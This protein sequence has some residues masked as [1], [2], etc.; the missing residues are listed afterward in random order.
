MIY[1]VITALLALYCEGRHSKG[2]RNDNNSRDLLPCPDW[3]SPHT[4][5]CPHPDGVVIAG[6]SFSGHGKKVALVD[7]HRQRIVSLTA[8]DDNRKNVGMVY[9]PHT[10]MLTVAG[11][12]IYNV[13]DR[14]LT[15]T[16]VVMQLNM[17]KENAEW[18]TFKQLPH[19]ASNPMMVCDDEYL[20][21][22]G[23]IGCA[24]CFRISR[25]KPVEW[26]ALDDLQQVAPGNEYDGSLYSGAVVYHGT[27]TVLTRTKYMMLNGLKWD[28]KEYRD[29]A[30]HEIKYLSPIIHR[31][32][33]V[34]SILLKQDPDEGEEEKLQIQLLDT[35]EHSWRKLMSAH[36]NGVIGA[37]RIATFKV[38]AV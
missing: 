6:S 36:K 11:G 20:Y 23:G 29:N 14:K 7:L 5:G 9:D 22:L 15:P 24:K 26:N 10:S 38:I 32:I 34:A 13:D 8:Q 4:R 21:V 37:G 3:Y 33:I 1:F 28:T 12:E 27:V 16:N 2:Y 19:L 30:N 25:N 18:E 35:E 31:G 17:S